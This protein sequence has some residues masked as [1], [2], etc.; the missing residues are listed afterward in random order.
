MKELLDQRFVT[1]VNS[2]NIIPC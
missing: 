1:H 2:K